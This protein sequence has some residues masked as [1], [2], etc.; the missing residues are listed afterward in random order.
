[1]AWGTSD[2]WVAIDFE[3][4]SARG[5]PCAVGLV[6]VEGGQIVD[7]HGWLICPP[8][9]EF[10]PFNV[11]L[12]G[13]TPEDCADAPDWEASLGEILAIIDGRT[14]VAHNASF[15]LG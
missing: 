12:H 2:T 9:F 11:A 15:D 7:H 8:R 13:I 4:A 14:V 5:T 10:S 3:T 1:M 6:E